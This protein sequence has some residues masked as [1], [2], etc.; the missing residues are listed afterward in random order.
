MK[1]NWA[2]RKFWSS[3][4]SCA[5]SRRRNCAF[6]ASS[7][8]KKALLREALL[9]MDTR[10]SDAPGFFEPRN[11]F[12]LRFAR[13]ANR[14]FGATAAKKRDARAASMLE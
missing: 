12:L 5:R 13:C 8:G 11:R 7:A 10:N 3:K 2:M 6:A 1:G 14:R 9:A 4:L